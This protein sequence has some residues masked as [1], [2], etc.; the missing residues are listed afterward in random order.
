MARFTRLEVWQQA[1]ELLRMVSLATGGMR[2]EG[3]LKSQIRRAAISIASNIAEGSEHGS[4]RE[5][6]RFLIIANASAAEVEA[7]AIIAGD[8]GC[9]DQRSADALVAKTQIVG[10]MLNRLMARVSSG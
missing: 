3:D 4:D 7:Q 10:R 9:L 8:I 5:F 2:A 1:R 6:L